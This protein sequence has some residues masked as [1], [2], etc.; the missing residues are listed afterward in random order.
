VERNTAGGTIVFRDEDGALVEVP[1]TGGN[2]KLQWK[3][4]WGMR[5]HALGVDYEMSGKDLIDSVKLSTQVCKILGSAAPEGLTYEHFLDQE[6]AKI[7]KS[8]GN[9]LSVEEWLTYAPQE[10][11]AYYMF[12]SPRKAKRLYFDVIPRQM[13]DYLSLRDKYGTQTPEQQI[14]N[15]VWHVHEGAMPGEKVPVTFSLLLNLVSAC[16]T[17]DKGTLW[18]FISR[19]VPGAN[20]SDMPFLDHML[21]FAITYYRDFILPNKITRTPNEMERAALLDLK[22]SIMGLAQD[23][24]ILQTEIFEVGKRH[25]F[26]DLKTW[27]KTLY[28]LLLGQNEGPR[29]GS[30][31]ALFGI[32]ETCA[33]IDKALER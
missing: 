27:F 21:D 13:D 12:Q 5:W 18:G 29:M 9:G 30:F 7:S 33:L 28:Q 4:D 1:V 6:G 14:D 20:A 10:S 23:P 17:E 31:V 11:L 8:K 2:V 25:D 26:A 15:P 16:Q 22:A 24:D 32:V 3:I 19:Y